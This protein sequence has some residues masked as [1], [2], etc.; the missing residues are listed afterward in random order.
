MQLAFLAGNISMFVDNVVTILMMAP[1]ALPLAR[2]L[3]LPV[4]PLVLMIGPYFSGGALGTW[5]L[6]AGVG[7]LV[8]GAIRCG[9]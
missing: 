8:W 6:A 9:L 3:A 5:M 7:V 2:A 1:V 4:F